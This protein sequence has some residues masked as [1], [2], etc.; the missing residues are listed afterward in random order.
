MR[1]IDALHTFC[2]H[3]YCPTCTISLIEK[4]IKDETFFPLKCCQTP[5]PVS[6][7]DSLIPPKLLEA[8]KEK[9]LEYKVSQQDRVY[10]VNSTCSTFLGS[11][12]GRS[13]RDRNVFC[14]K[15]KTSTC[16]KCK[17]DTHE[18]A[19][20]A[21]HAAGILLRQL[22]INS[23]WQTCPGCKAIVEKNQGCNHI[24]CR[25]G[26]QFCYLCSCKWKTCRCPQ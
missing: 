16:A 14:H 3:D 21:A 23:K 4:V 15:C 20:C 11:S 2:D 12:Q 8:Y 26:A 19:D 9:Q 25:C 7:F 1:Y 5:I 6:E 24:T 22:A 18:E 10:C 13:S 17:G